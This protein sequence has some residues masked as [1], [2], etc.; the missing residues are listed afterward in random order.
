M[1]LSRY[2]ELGRISQYVSP[3]KPLRLPR[4][5][6]QLPRLELDLGRQELR[7]AQWCSECRRTGSALFVM[8]L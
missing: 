7:V 1:F 5:G 6:T 3:L 2:T 4:N 8:L